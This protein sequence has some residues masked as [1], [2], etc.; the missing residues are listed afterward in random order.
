MTDETAK[1]NW[2][3]FVQKG[4]GI[5]GIKWVENYHVFEFFT[6]QCANLIQLLRS[7]KIELAHIEENSLRSAF[8]KLA[9]K[10][11]SISAVLNRFY[12]GAIAYYH[13]KLQRLDV[14]MEALN[15]A[16]LAVK[17]AVQSRQFLLPFAWH[18]T[19][20]YVQRSRIFILLD[21]LNDA[22]FE[23]ECFL[24]IL[25]GTKPLCRTYE[26]LPLFVSSIGKFVRRCGDLN[27]EEILETEIFFNSS[28][29]NLYYNETIHQIMILPNFC[30]Y[31]F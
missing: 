19:D 18:I 6:K 30:I 15:S 4:G 2:L 29:R 8:T 7:N 21:K 3:K 10:D 31:Y 5:K 1:F 12:L 17:E 25:N 28:T 22:R 24:A 13:Y 20:F 9:I 14:G 16:E 23:L 11:H 26:G 27:P